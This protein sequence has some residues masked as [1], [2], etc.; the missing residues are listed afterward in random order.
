MPPVS[1]P[2]TPVTLT[3]SLTLVAGSTGGTGYILDGPAATARFAGPESIA[4]DGAGN[5]YVIDQNSLRK[6]SGQ[7]V[8]TVVSSGQRLVHGPLTADTAGNVYYSENGE[9]S[10]R[11]S[12]TGTDT[13]VS[14][15]TGGEPATFDSQGNFYFFV[16]HG[17]VKSAIYYTINRLSPSGTVTELTDSS[18]APAQFTFPAGVAIDASGTMYVVEKGFTQY[19]IV[20]FMP[21]GQRTDLVP[22]SESAAFAGLV[23]DASGNLYSADP[24]H[25]VVRKITPA[26]VSTVFAGLLDTVGAADGKGLAARFNTPGS[27]A[28]D[29]AGDLVVGDRGNHTVR[30]IAADA[31]VATV[32]GV[33]SGRIFGSA[34]GMGTAAQFGTPQGVTADAAGNLYVA[35]TGSH[36]IRKITPAGAVTT[37]AGKAGET[38]KVNGTAAEARFNL[39]TDV[40]LDAAGNL[41][42][43]D[44]GNALVRKITPAGIVS[45]LAGGGPTPEQFITNGT[46]TAASFLRPHGLAIDAAGNLFVTD[47]VDTSIRKITPTGEVTSFAGSLK[48]TALIDGVGTATQFGSPHGIAI[49]RQGN[50][51]VADTGNCALRKITP[52]A[53]VSTVPNTRGSFCGAMAIAVDSAGNLYVTLATEPSSTSAYQSTVVRVA[54]DGTVSPFVG[55]PNQ[56]RIELGALPGS[57]EPPYGITRLDDKHFV[58]TSAGAVLKA[59]ID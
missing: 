29:A 24:T 19:G 10:H 53:V 3:G 2:S 59:T 40:A 1:T 20:K 55:K 48:F 17:G 8:T 56:Q 49:D 37:L 47:S 27:I 13:I 6:V 38:G 51:Y 58:F 14:L 57:I 46:G 7:T 5:I 34:D 52:D 35:D 15:G 12:P 30:R 41:Y 9:G 28:I 11:I 22:A 54:Q 32:A 36:T 42:V 23:I 44:S 43:A 25:H 50:L 31:T 16:F 33:A 26:G 45:T 21:G 18:G 4:V 39:P